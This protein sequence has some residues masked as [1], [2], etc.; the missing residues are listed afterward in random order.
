MIVASAIKLTN[1]EIYVGK[2][3]CDCFAMI[4]LA[5]EKTN[6]YSEE[7]LRK[8]H[9]NCEQGFITDKLK[10]MNRYEAWDE[11][12]RCKQINETQFDE[13]YSEDLW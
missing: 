6:F 4:T 13:L 11:A 7:E 10:F 2:R 5:N 9:I 8:L 3:H 12:F 1:G